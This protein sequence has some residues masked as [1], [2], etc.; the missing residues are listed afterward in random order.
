MDLHRLVNDVRRRVEHEITFEGTKKRTECVALLRRIVQLIPMYPSSFLSSLLP[1][2]PEIVHHVLT[3]GGYTPPYPHRPSKDI[4]STISPESSQLS[5][6][7]VNSPYPHNS[8]LAPSFIPIL[9]L[10]HAHLFDGPFGTLIA[11]TRKVLA[12]ANFAIVFEECLD[13]A[14]EVLFDNLEKNVFHSSYNPGKAKDEEVRIRLAGLLPALSRWSQL[15]LDGLPNELVDVSFLFRA[16]L[17]FV[18]LC[19]QGTNH[20]S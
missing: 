6:E 14:M 2:T 4:K 18:V 10:P 16:F 11:E 9:P 19:F 3:Q 13:C 1:P 5:H 7:F 20:I 12:S 15:A 17:A 8:K